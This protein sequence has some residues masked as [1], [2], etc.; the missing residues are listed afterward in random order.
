M[1]GLRL[2]ARGE[3]VRDYLLATAAATC[4]AV[5]LISAA[6]IFKMIGF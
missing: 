3:A 2:T 6:C 1:K 5:F 4:I